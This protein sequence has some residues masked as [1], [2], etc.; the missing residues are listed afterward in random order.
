LKLFDQGC[1]LTGKVLIRYVS[2]LAKRKRAPRFDLGALL[3]ACIGG[4]C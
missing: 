1:L 4:P 2:E 3:Y